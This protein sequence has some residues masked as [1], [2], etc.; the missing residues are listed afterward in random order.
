MIDLMALS[1]S[2]LRLSEVEA[3]LLC[4]PSISDVVSHLNGKRSNQRKVAGTP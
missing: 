2:L 4:V 3:N 1:T